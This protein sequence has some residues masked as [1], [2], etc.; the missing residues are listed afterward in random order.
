MSRIQYRDQICCNIA[1][2]AECECK[3]RCEEVGYQPCAVYEERRDEEEDEWDPLESFEVEEFARSVG[4][5]LNCIERTDDDVGGGQSSEG[6]ESDDT[7]GPAEG[8]MGESSL[9]DDG[10]DNA[11]NRC[12]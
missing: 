2:G 6:N 5:D 3:R 8:G 12:T 4:A 1:R 11:A 7:G 10:V 9:E